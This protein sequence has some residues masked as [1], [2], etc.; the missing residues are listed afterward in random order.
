MKNYKQILVLSEPRTGSNAYTANL[1]ESLGFGY[2]LEP[3]SK[4]DPIV[5]WQRFMDYINEHEQYIIKIHTRQFFTKY[6]KWFQMEMLSNS[7]YRIA[8]KRRNF[9]EQIASF[10]IAKMRNIW[11]YNSNTII[12][13]RLNTIHIDVDKIDKYITELKEYNIENYSLSVNKTIYYEDLGFITNNHFVKS[14]L[15]SNYQELL[16][17]IQERINDQLI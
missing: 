2:F 16:Q 9:A 1:A 14:T 6:P 10:Y 8:I 5:A 17:A 3:D 11:V 15:P 13:E 7:T 4:P 12:D